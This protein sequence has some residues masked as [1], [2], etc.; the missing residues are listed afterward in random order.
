MV[1]EIVWICMASVIAVVMFVKKPQDWND[2]V[3]SFFIGL[4]TMMLILGIGGLFF[5]IGRLIDIS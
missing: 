1:K 4:L 3:K 5:I 2:L